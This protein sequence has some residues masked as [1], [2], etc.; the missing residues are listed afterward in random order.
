MKLWMYK[1]NCHNARMTRVDYM[2]GVIQA[3]TY[4]EAERKVAS[5]MN[6]YQTLANIHEIDF[7]NPESTKLWIVGGRI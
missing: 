7:D 6:D 3:A 1:L 2:I 4:N 5:M